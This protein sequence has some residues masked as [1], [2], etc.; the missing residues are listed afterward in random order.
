V[1]A[2]KRGPA[3]IDLRSFTGYR[4]RC[5][6][7][8]RREYKTDDP[9]TLRID[10]RRG[11]VCP[12]GG[13]R[14]TACTNSGITTRRILRRVAGAVL[15]Q[16]GSDGANIIFDP[17]HLE[18]VAGLLRLKKRRRRMNEAERTAAAERLSKIR[19]SAA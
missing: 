9:W 4:V 1:I 6:D 2:S 18:T 14:L 19:P 8:D 3:C 17:A 12:H 10:G 11:F 13:D 7:E 16:D 5:E 15:W